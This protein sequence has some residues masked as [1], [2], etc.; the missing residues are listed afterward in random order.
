MIIITT[1]GLHVYSADMPEETE[2]N[3]SG[4]NSAMFNDP[5]EGDFSPMF[6]EFNTNQSRSAVDVS[7]NSYVGYDEFSGFHRCEDRLGIENF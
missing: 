7:V 4:N 5:V 1:V 3:R 6:D 2:I